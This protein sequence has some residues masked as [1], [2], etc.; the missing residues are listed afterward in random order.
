VFEL[1]HLPYRIGTEDD[2]AP[3][4]TRALVFRGKATLFQLGRAVRD[5][6][7]RDVQR[8]SA[9]NTLIWQGYIAESRS[10]LWTEIEDSETILLTGKTHNLRLTI[11]SLNGVEVPA[12]RVF[13]LWRQVGRTSRLK[14]YV[15]GR[16][17][18][19]G[20]LIPNIGGGLCQ[21]SNA[22]Y[23]AA[24]NADSISRTGKGA[25][26]RQQGESGIIRGE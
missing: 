19:E 2:A 10:P 11:R 20:C 16:A 12:E 6:V 21:L 5:S 9:G 26:L 3:R 22:L 18:R 13:S 8:F 15:A 23:D 1:N 14:G 17:L 7:G 4:I 25:R 24:L